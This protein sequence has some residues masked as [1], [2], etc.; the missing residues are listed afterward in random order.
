MKKINRN[1]LI[2]SKIPKGDPCP[3]SFTCKCINKNCPTFYKTKKEDFKCNYAIIKSLE[4]ETKE[5]I[6]QTKEE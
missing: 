2:E 6:K 3:Y 4:E 1:G 5:P